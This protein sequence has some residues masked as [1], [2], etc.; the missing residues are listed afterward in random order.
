MQSTG[1]M[2]IKYPRRSVKKTFAAP[3]R[4]YTRRKPLAISS[5]NAA[6]EIKFIDKAISQAFDTTGTVTLCANMAQGIDATQ[7]IGRMTATKSFELKLT[8]AVTPAT[9]VDQRVRWLLVYDKQ[10]NAAIPA[11]TDILTAI[12]VNA[13]RNMDN[14]DRFVLLYDQCVDLNASAESGSSVHISKFR[15][16][17]PPYPTVWNLN[18]AA[19]VTSIS[20]GSFVFITIGDQ[21]AGTTASTCVGTIRARFLDA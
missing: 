18:A 21:A 3:R 7:R 8:A 5:V 6:K 12:D 16:L 20:T 1:N 17:F 11:I 2:Y 14:R 4:A 10:T 13:M 9:G 19:S 15:Y